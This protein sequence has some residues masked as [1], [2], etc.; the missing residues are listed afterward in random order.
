M[1]KCFMPSSEWFFADVDELSYV[2]FNVFWPV[3]WSYDGEI[4]WSSE[5]FEYV[6]YDKS[7]KPSKQFKAPTKELCIFPAFPSSYPITDTELGFLAL[8]FV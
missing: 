6:V 2:F 5:I 8:K 3:Y 4:N 1:L 7:A